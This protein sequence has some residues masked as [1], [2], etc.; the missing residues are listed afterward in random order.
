MHKKQYSIGEEVMNSVTHG[1][2]AVFSVIATLIMLVLTF[3]KGA[4]FISSALIFGLSLTLLYT[5]STL[6]HAIT[7][8]KAK[9]VLQ[10]FDHSTI[11]ILIAGTYAP[12]ALITLKGSVG[13]IVLSVV[14][15]IAIV[16]II[17]NIISVDRFKKLSLILYI[18]SGWTAVL[19]IK[20]IVDNLALGGVIL[21]GVGG[22][23]YTIGIIFYKLKGKRFFHGIWHL[24]VLAG[25]VS[26]FF[27]IALYV[28]K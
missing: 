27:S 14:G 16:G 11:Y 6:Y 26:H 7:N 9:R 4:R 25:S 10:A 21:M 23:F 2:G 8:D 5:M 22:L 24:F 15:L 17:L 28:L 3:N 18:I 19:A 12:Y 13:I 20:P 1:V